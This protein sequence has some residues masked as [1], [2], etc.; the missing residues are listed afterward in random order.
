LL[1]GGKTSTTAP[2]YVLGQLAHRFLR[3]DTSFAARKRSF[4]FIDG[5][6]DFRAGALA[7]LPQGKGLLHRVFLAPKPPALN[8][9][10]D[11]SSLV[12]GELHF[13]TLLSLGVDKASV[14]R[15]FVLPAFYGKLSEACLVFNESRQISLWPGA[16]VRG[17]RHQ[18]LAD[19]FLRIGTG[20]SVEQPLATRRHYYSNK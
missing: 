3:D 11:K 12:G 15:G 7:L 18:A 20:G 5:G 13:H 1:L 4:S 16:C 17:L 14:K 19:V 9:L 10:A 2:L 6:K 8:S